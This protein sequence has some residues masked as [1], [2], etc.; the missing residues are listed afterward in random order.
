MRRRTLLACGGAL[1]AGSLA[2]CLGPTGAGRRPLS[3]NPVGQGLDQQPRLGPPHSEA[4][5]VLVSFQ[6]PA[7]TNCADFHDKTFPDI[8]REWL[9]TGTATFFARTAHVGG[10]AV[11]AAHALE[12]TR[13]RTPEL[14]WDLKG[15]Y[16]ENQLDMA[17]G[18]VA[19][20]TRSFL[21]DDPVDAAAVA[22]AARTK[23]HTEALQT[24]ASAFSK[25]AYVPST[26]TTWLFEDGEF[27]TVV[28]NQTFDSF[29][30]AAESRG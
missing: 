18:D 15:W 26:P 3:E 25:G 20:Q 4:R 13:R 29:V 5:L 21:A 28:Y 12:E 30:A 7:C 14:Y 11:A 19:D 9:R 8:R 24:D 22:E 17:E 1:A 6:S 16:Y 23:P 10:W 27:V 2:G